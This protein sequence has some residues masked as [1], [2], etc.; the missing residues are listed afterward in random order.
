MTVVMKT[1]FL[2]TE[3]GVVSFKSKFYYNSISYDT[4]VFLL[5]MVKNHQLSSKTNTPN[6]EN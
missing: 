4:T 1:Q 2:R 6:G 5:E 3:Q